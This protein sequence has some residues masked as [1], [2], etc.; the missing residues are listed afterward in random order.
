MHGHLTKRWQRTTTER[1]QIDNET[2]SK[3]QI[4]TSS[5]KGQSRN[6]LSDESQ[7]LKK[8]SEMQIEKKV[9]KKEEVRA[10]RPPIPF[11]QRLKQSKL[12]DQFAK[13]L[14]MF[15]K[16]EINIPLFEA[17]AQMPH[18]AKFMKDIINKKGNWMKMEW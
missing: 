5:K 3:Y 17:L 18:Y 7:Q 2:K 16:I 15:K 12:D 11:P 9:Q 8:N 1:K 6:E 4:P 13:F 10:Y 14:N